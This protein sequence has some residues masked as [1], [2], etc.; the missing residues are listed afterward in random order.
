[1]AKK[2]GIKELLLMY[3]LSDPMLK[4]RYSEAKKL[5]DEKINVELAIFVNSQQEVIKA[6]SLTKHIVGRERL[7]EDKR[8]K[9][10]IDFESSRKPDF[11]HHRRGGLTQVHVKT[12]VRTGKTILVNANPLITN[13]LHQS[14]LLGRFQQNSALFKKYGADVKVVSGATRSLD[15]RA[16]KDL[17]N[18]LKL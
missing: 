5:A 13:K 11:I 2:L 12:A 1:M 17:D 16:P 9:Y 14:V 15:M 10:L 3:N 8:V 4:Q 6:K 7:Y 18:L